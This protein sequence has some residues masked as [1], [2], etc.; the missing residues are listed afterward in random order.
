MHS[1][2]LDWHM[3]HVST[4]WGIMHLLL[5]L[6]HAS[7]GLSL[8]VQPFTGSLPWPPGAG[9]VSIWHV[10]LGGPHP[11]VLPGR[12]VRVDDIGLAEVHD[13]CLSEKRNHVEIGE[14][15]CPPVSYSCSG[16]KKGGTHECCFF[17][18]NLPKG[19]GAIKNCFALWNN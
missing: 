3:I 4:S 6:L 18:V 12:E 19:K 5:R 9:F 15:N 14:L 13:C 11:R 1:S 17:N 7:Q 2:D 8:L 10:S 16:A